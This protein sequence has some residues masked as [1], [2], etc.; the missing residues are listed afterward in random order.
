MQWRPTGTTSLFRLDLAKC[1][2]AHPPPSHV[3]SVPSLPAPRTLIP[4]YIF[5]L[6][7]V[8]QAAAGGRVCSDA[9]WVRVAEAGDRVV[10]II[11]PSS[12]PVDS[13]S[14]G[15]AWTTTSY[16]ACMQMLRS[17]GVQMVG[18]VA[19]KLAS[20]TSPGV[21]TQTGLRDHAIVTADVDSWFS[22]DMGGLL[23]GIFFDEVSNLWQVTEMYY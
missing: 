23:S 11:N 22:G 2:A 1:A 3:P 12:G 7:E 14:S 15:A 13:S 21:W 4:L 10:A 19:T 8:D 9:S 17:S 5:P 18:Y 20:E 16:L 6:T